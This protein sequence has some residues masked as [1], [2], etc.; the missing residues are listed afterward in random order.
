ML[1]DPRQQGPGRGKPGF[2]YLS[3]MLGQV[4]TIRYRPSVGSTLLSQEVCV[5][6]IRTR[7][8]YHSG[9]STCEIFTGDQAVGQVTFARKLRRDATACIDGDEI[10]FERQRR[11]GSFVCTTS[12]HT[13]LQA[14]Q[15]LRLLGKVF[16][17]SADGQSYIPRRR[18]SGLGY[19]L[20]QNGIKVGRF[21]STRWFDF[22]AELPETLSP[23]AIC[24]F[25]WLTVSQMRIDVAWSG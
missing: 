8:H 7:F 20:Y 5:I 22:H 12:G 16:F 15:R 4:S 3:S 13:D 25:V 23:H 18:Q 9:L 11:W 14:T 21:W 10:E 24:F 17:V 2:N 19:T 6:K 1:C